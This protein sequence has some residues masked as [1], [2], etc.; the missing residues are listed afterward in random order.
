[1]TIVQSFTRDLAPLVTAEKALAATAVPHTP[2][3]IEATTAQDV[4]AAVRMARELD[5]PL[6]V[7]A[8][9]HGSFVAPQGGFQ[10]ET[11]GLGGVTI[12]P[13][14][15]VARVGAGARWGDVL[16]AA[17]PYGLAGLS[18]TS[19][20]V[21]VTGYTLGGGL[22]W[23]SRKYGYAADNLLSA[24]VVTADGSLLTV[25]ADQHPDLFWALRGGGANFGVVTS[26][27]F[28]L[29]PVARVF[30]GTAYFPFSRAADLLV[31]FR[32]WAETREPDELTT[33]IVLVRSA[34]HAPVSG[35]VVAV[36]GL[37]VGTP[38]EARRALAPLWKVAGEPLADTWRT[39][40]YTETGTIGGIAPRRF[41]TFRTL[42]GPVI[43]TALSLVSDPEVEELEVRHWGGAMR[44]SVGRG[45][46]GHRNVPFSIAVN[47]TPSAADGLAQYATGGA[48]LNFLKD[49]SRTASAYT[50]A[51]WR[52]LRE[53]K[54]TYDPTNLFGLNHNIRPGSDTVARDGYPLQ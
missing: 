53:L 20:A 45:P 10:L 49:P 31:K 9:G 42:S 19:P 15:Q 13:A 14:R 50:T 47:G 6:A 44:R 34:A 37:Y 3:G 52:R 27:T 7:H 5:V 2:V 25:D 24:D 39:M 30:A 22:S 26:L 40:P 54:R 32:V 48:F 36:R 51:N 23:L 11:A 38:E 1:M 46:V 43:Q 18:G 16:A 4:Q 29:F 8:T 35:P 28:R 41:E 33:S 12:D 17:A 21:G